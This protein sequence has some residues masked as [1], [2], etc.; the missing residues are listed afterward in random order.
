M[1][2]V[3]IPTSLNLIRSIRSLGHRGSVHL[4]IYLCMPCTL[5]HVAQST[6]FMGVI[7]G[8]Y[9]ANHLMNSMPRKCG[10]LVSHSGMEL[11][12]TTSRNRLIHRASTNKWRSQIAW[13]IFS[14]GLSRILKPMMCDNNR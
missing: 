2:I 1:A 6:P 10:H 9:L 12:G 7:A 3:E 4:V 14:P 5:N 8:N 11:T 13:A